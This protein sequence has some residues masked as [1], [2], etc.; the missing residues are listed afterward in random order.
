[1]ET[2]ADI[3]FAWVARMIMMGLYVTGEVPYKNRCLAEKVPME[4]ME[5]EK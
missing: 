4:D 3:L 5:N 2:G 1:M